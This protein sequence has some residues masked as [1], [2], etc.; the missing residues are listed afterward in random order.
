MSTFESDRKLERE[1]QAIIDYFKLICI[2]RLTT[3][4]FDENVNFSTIEM[5]G[6]SKLLRECLKNNNNKIISLSSLNIDLL[7][8]LR[9]NLLEIQ[10]SKASISEIYID[11]FSNLNWLYEVINNIDCNQTAWDTIKRNANYCFYNTYLKNINLDNLENIAIEDTS[12]LGRKDLLNSKI[13]QIQKRKNVLNSQIKRIS[14]NI[15][16][17]KKMTFK[18]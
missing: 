9:N 18:V 5:L 1:T 15:Q 13:I 12:L 2:E 10:K 17:Q 14:D 6:G 11:N 8:T 7:T 4:N 16:I 3:S